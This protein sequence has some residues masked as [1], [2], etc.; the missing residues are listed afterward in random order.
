M[1]LWRKEIVFALMQLFIYKSHSAGL[2]EICGRSSECSTEFSH[3]DENIRKC[4]CRPHT[5]EHNSTTCLPGTLLGFECKTDAQCSVKVSTSGCVNGVCT[6]GDG[7]SPYRRHTCLPPAK[8]GEICFDHDQCALADSGAVCKF[9]VPRVFGRCQ[10]QSGMKLDASGTNNAMCVP[11]GTKV[12]HH[13]K[14][15]SDCT[16]ENAYCQRKLDGS[17]VCACEVSFSPSSDGTRCL[18]TY[19]GILSP[20]TLGYPCHANL[21][22]QLADPNSLCILGICDCSS[23]NSTK[24]CNAVHTGCHPSTFQCVGQGKCVSWYFVCDGKID[25]PDGSDEIC[26]VSEQCPK[27][28]FQ[29]KTNSDGLEKDKNETMLQNNRT[30]CISRSKLC[31]GVADCDEGEDEEGC[32][33]RERCPQGTFQC[34]TTK[35]CLPEHHF[36]NSIADCKDLSDE[37][38]QKCK[39]EFHPFI[40]PEFCPFRCSNGLCRSS[41]IVCSG[42]NGCGDFSDEK[43]CSVCRCPR[44]TT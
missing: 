30:K 3:C 8:F 34:A 42:V 28:T 18:H 14:V 32:S 41:A 43:A 44:R 4:V 38:E 13:C 9:V 20:T 29:C 21:Q 12:G 35:E 1:I 17:A 2:H 22:C 24:K 40:H 37:N 23:Q 27:Q 6:C 39:L 25:C 33:G 15:D 5:V 26:N 7:H 19:R 31:D 11:R 36:C 16:F 10:C